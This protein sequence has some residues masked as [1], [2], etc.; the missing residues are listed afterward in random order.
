MTELTPKSLFVVTVAMAAD[1]SRADLL[2]MAAILNRRG[3]DVVEA[4]LSRPAHGRRVFSATFSSSR[5]QAE[6][7]LRSIEGLVDVVDAALFSAL[8]ART[9]SEARVAH[10]PHGSG[11]R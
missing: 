11:R 8:D 3:A 1:G 10:Q 5:I 4:E 9:P 6:T 2:Q 7:V